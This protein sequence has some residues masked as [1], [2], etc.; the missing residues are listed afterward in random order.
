MHLFRLF[1]LRGIRFWSSAL[2][3]PIS[4]A[5][6]MRDG[7]SAYFVCSSIALFSSDWVYSVCGLELRER[8]KTEA[9]VV[10]RLGP[11]KNV[12]CSMHKAEPILSSVS[13]YHY[14]NTFW[15]D[16]PL[17]SY[18]NSLSYADDL[19]HFFSSSKC[20]YLLFL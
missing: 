12:V 13:R 16:L 20:S 4:T 15:V 6:Y 19:S 9:W 1:V 10:M 7:H 17:L 11:R 8:K 5:K 2:Y 14:S 3:S 18:Y